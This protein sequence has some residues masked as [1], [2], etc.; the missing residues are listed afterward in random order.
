MSP[1]W[2][3]IIASSL[4]ALSLGAPVRAD[5]AT[6][7]YRPNVPGV[8]RPVP[9]GNAAES[10][11]G[12]MNAFRSAYARA[13]SPRIAIFWNRELTD[14]ISTSY[15]RY[16]EID[17]VN[18]GIGGVVVGNGYAA[19]VPAVSATRVESA[20]TPIAEP[21]R[22]K[23]LAGHQEFRV[24]SA[25][26][27]TML[28]GGARLIDRNTIIRLLGLQQGGS[29]RNKQSLE[30]RAL[31]DKAEYFVEVLQTD[32]PQSPI[33]AALQV[34]VTE[35][36]TGRILA[37]VAPDQKSRQAPQTRFVAGAYGFEKQEI[38]PE[39]MNAQQ[40]GKDL[41]MQTMEALTISM[42]R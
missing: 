20:E 14:S 25:F 7:I 13:G 34:T 1:K 22:E 6:P 29:A 41:A 15:R 26:A 30:M 36:R 27:G 33:G 42:H 8:L 31:L 2:T 37:S 18:L 19:T 3:A 40:I 39:A 38:T 16:L 5:E 17:Q 11:A 12:V 28:K 10:E 32:D 24:E 9:Q 23:A 21:E 35:V 4:M